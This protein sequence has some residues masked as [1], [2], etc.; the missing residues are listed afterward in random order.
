MEESLWKENL[1]HFHL[2]HIYS[3]VYSEHIA[4]PAYSS[5]PE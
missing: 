4:S 3:T 1:G 5:L 2:N